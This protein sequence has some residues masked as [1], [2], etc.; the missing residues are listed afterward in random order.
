MEWEQG[1]KVLQRYQFGSNKAIGLGSGRSILN[2]PT[3]KDYLWIDTK[4]PRRSLADYPPT[5][6]SHWGSAWAETWIKWGIRWGKGLQGI[7]SHQWC[8]LLSGWNWQRQM[9]DTIPVSSSFEPTWHTLKNNKKGS[10]NALFQ[11]V[12]FL[13]TRARGYLSLAVVPKHPTS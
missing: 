5:S 7:D 2:N 11:V 9:W 13:M 4:W 10:L 3:Q 1:G 6:S 8:Q 12:F